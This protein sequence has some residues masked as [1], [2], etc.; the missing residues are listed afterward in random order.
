MTLSPRQRNHKE[1]ENR[2]KDDSESSSSSVESSDEALL[3]LLGMTSLK[4]VSTA[5]EQISDDVVFDNQ[6]GKNATN[7]CYSEGFSFNSS[8]LDAVICCRFT[9]ILLKH[10]AS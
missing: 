4:Q 2:T 7:D 6:V 1:Q 5:A 9:D 3:E 10:P 8:S